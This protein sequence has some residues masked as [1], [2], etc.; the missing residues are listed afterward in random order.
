[1]SLAANSVTSALQRR[2]VGQRNFAVHAARDP[3]P[4]M[5]LQQRPFFLGIPWFR[6]T[7][8]LALLAPIQVRVGQP[9]YMEL[10]R[11]DRVNRAK[12]AAV[13]ARLSKIGCWIPAWF[14]DALAGCAAAS[15]P[16]E[17]DVKSIRHRPPGLPCSEPRRLP[18]ELDS[19]ASL[20]FLSSRGK[21]G[22]FSI[23][24]VGRRGA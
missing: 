7:G 8:T 22:N 4:G 6:G 9:A 23:D 13:F 18:I 16:C 19:S 12:S 24:F 20:C 17:G 5:S 21:A 2:L 10:A 14:G 1:M 11:R 3:H 15:S